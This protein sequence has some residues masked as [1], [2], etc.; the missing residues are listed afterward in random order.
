MKETKWSDFIHTSSLLHL[1]LTFN[2]RGL[3]R[4]PRKENGFNQDQKNVAHLLANQSS[5]VDQ[6]NYIPPAKILISLKESP[7]TLYR[8]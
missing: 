7:T 6:V 8:L 3:G 4:I 2:K 5:V 1:I